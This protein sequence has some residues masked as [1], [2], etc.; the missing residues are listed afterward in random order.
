MK[1]DDTRITVFKEDYNPQRKVDTSGKVLNEGKVLYSKGQK[2][3]I[4]YKVLESIK[5][6]GAKFEAEKLDYKKA[7]DEKKA[8]MAQMKKA[9]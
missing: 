6:R 2:Y 8:K 3:A 5:K 9:A 7:I 1:Y 4:H